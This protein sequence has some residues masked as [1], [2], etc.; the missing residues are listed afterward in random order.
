MSATCSERPAYPHWRPLLVLTIAAIAAGLPEAA[1][2]QS[3]TFDL[4]D[5]STV[6]DCASAC[7]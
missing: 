3:V 7:V 6:T 4:G 5:G 2:A 1:V